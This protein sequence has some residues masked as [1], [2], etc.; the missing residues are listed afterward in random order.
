MKKKDIIISDKYL[1]IIKLILIISSVILSNLFQHGLLMKYRIISSILVFIITFII[2]K[3][4]K[5]DKLNK[6]KLLCSTLIALYTS[7]FILGF[8]N[9]NPYNLITALSNKFNY[10]F[11]YEI[12]FVLFGIGIIPILTLYI[13][14]FIKN[15]LPKVKDFIINLTKVEKIYL[16]IITIIG[17]LISGVVICTTT[18]FTVPRIENGQLHYYDIVY[19]ADNGAIAS[20]DAYL[21]IPHLENDIRQPLFALFASPFSITAH[22]ISELLPFSHDDKNYYFVMI[23]FQFIITTI[24]TI[25]LSK[26]LSLNEKDKI[27][28]YTL[29][30][31]SF[32]YLIF[33]IVLEQYVIGLFYLI[34]TIY[35]YKESKRINYAYLGGVSTLLTT[36]ILFPLITHKEKIKD[37]INELFKAFMVFVSIFILCGGLQMVFTLLDRL[38]FLMSFTGREVLLVEKIQ[39]FTHFIAG[40]FIAPTG[41]VI[42]NS[43]GAISYQL[44]APTTISILGI[45]IF[46]ICIVS[47]ILNRKEYLA[48]ISLF[49]VLFSVFVLLGMGWGTQENGLILYSLYF[50]WGYLTL[51]YLFIKKLFTN[52]KL[53]N[54]V[55]ITIIILMIFFNFKELINVL[56]FAIM[57]Y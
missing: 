52:K 42:N 28:F 38:R 50:G 54:I 22:A 49:W 13:Y 2:L 55:F 40:I 27:Y 9:N 31:I 48:R 21:D 57:N 32:P 53:F 37:K 41:E 15:I 6:T 26:L 8:A 10:Q 56:K 39:Q 16:G 43:F 47:A 33:N 29:F 14:L 30:S 5:L 11:I 23:I 24:T 19:T 7:K 4:F 20:D 12:L 18:A 51:I 36:G 35:M 25:M 3:Q 45:T 44:I 34:L 46:V 17:T 1:N